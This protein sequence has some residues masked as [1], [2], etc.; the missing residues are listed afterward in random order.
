MRRLA[1]ELGIQAPSLYKHFPDKEAITT[2]IHVDYLTGQR[3]ALVAALA[4]RGD[5]HPVEALAQA[6][7]AY[8][9]ANEALYLYL[10]LLPYPRAAA[11][12]VL[13]TIRVQ[14][15]KATGDSDLAIACYGFVRGMVDMELHGLYP[16][17]ASPDGAYAQGLAALIHRVKEVDALRPTD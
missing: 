9:V 2:A 16:I 13:K 1:D 11:S 7:R 4:E 15:F 5:E 14:W 10:F 8:A 6:Y 3:D 12:E 17:D